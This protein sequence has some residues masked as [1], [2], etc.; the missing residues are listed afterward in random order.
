[1][2][3]PRVIPVIAIALNVSD[4]WLGEFKELEAALTL[5]KEDG[6][7]AVAAKA[8]ANAAARFEK[9]LA[10]GDD[11]A[12]ETA[13]DGLFAIRPFA[14]AEMQKKADDLILG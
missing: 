7:D 6:G 2:V 11:A 8:V 12:K 14:D 13:K 1:M 10:S 4:L 9:M 3:G 5:L